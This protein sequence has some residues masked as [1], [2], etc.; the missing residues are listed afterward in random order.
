M[1]LVVLLFL[2]GDAAY[3]AFSLYSVQTDIADAVEDG[4]TALREGE[5]HEAAF[6]FGVAGERARDGKSLTDHPV[7]RLGQLLPFVSNDLDAVEHLVSAAGT[8]ADAGVAAAELS[9][10]LDDGGEFLSGI[11]A[12]GAVNVAAVEGAVPELQEIAE[13][14]QQAQDELESAPR[15][16]VG[17]VL[18]ELTEA[19]E[20]LGGAVRAGLRGTAAITALP[21][22]LGEGSRKDYLL[23]F[24][25]PSEGRATGGFMGL[26]GRLTASNGQLEL[27]QVGRPP[28]RVLFGKI[29]P[30]PAP[31]WFRGRYG[32]QASQY[33]GQASYPAHFPTAAENILRMINAGTGEDL[34]GVIALDPIA[35]GFLLEGSAP[36]EVPHLGAVTSENAA[37]TVLRDS[38]I[39]ITSD[40]QNR[41]LARLM[42][43]FWSR[44]SDGEVDMPS[45]V[46]GFGRAASELHLKVYS[47]NEDAQASLTAA[48]AAGD[49]TRYGPNVQ[50]VFHNNLTD[51][52][53]DWFMH[54]TIETVV[55]L[56][57]EGNARVTT[58]IA[59]ENRATADGPPLLVGGRSK[60]YVAGEN[61]MF[62]NAI[63]PRD[64]RNVEMRFSGDPIPFKSS[65]EVDRPTVW[66]T[67]HVPPR[68]TALATVT[69]TVPDMVDLEA[70]EPRFDLTLFPHAVVNAD[71]YYLL[72]RPPEGWQLSRP[73]SFD[74]PREFHEESG[75]LS[76]PRRVVL[77]LHD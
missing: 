57:E 17:R 77:E 35:L 58:G 30:V 10:D 33:W 54:R 6:S 8:A 73:V 44:V 74:E 15:P 63:L 12:N 14:L 48:G 37:S 11:Y 43:V 28:E 56:D 4:K 25:S 22:L 64:A 53:I 52:K 32:E 72:V 13:L 71:R 18:T 69:Y 66:E 47:R 51:G 75:V 76:E 38:Y 68:S 60:A 62:L 50:F 31:S 1:L 26:V 9:R 19:N 42:R 65:T 70:D 27:L 45:L 3:V 5:P 59:V 16:R 29:D 67:L 46:R 21:E 36:I 23:V 34:E 24:Q 40:Q 2:L 39:G 55:R 20:E 41:A 7:Y 49:F 61:R